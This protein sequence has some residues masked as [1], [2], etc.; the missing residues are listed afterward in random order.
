MKQPNGLGAPLRTLVRFVVHAGLCTDLEHDIQL[1][2]F[3]LPFVR[4]VHRHIL[5][6]GTRLPLQHESLPANA[7]LFSSVVYVNAEQLEVDAAKQTYTEELQC[8]LEVHI[9]FF[10]CSGSLFAFCARRQPALR[11]KRV[12]RCGFRA[13][14]AGETKLAF[15][16]VPGKH[17]KTR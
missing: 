17:S 9:V 5:R 6:F 12:Q 14:V 1:L 8:G 3:A 11:V 2:L 16:A 4:A 7:A 10:R 13:I 15:T